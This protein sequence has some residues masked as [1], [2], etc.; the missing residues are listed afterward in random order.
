MPV[1]VAL[2]RL[3]IIWFIFVVPVVILDAS[4]VLLRAAPGEMASPAI[5]PMHYF[6]LFQPWNVYAKYDHHYQASDD[7]FTPCQAVLNLCEITLGLAAIAIDML[8][9]HKGALILGIM[10]CTMMIYKTIIFFLMDVFEGG[11]YTKHNTFQDKLLMIWIPSSFWIIIPAILL[12]QIFSAFE[13]E[14]KNG[15]RIP[16]SNSKK[17][18]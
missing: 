2:P 16:I 8:E 11:E 14:V 13:R 1:Y 5:H 15:K 4:Y 12:T 7:A 3:A 6:P 18:R 10:L 9:Y 17:Q